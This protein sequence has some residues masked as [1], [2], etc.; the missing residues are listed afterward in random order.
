MERAR[1]DEHLQNSQP[2]GQGQR[3]CLSHHDFRA[4]T[5]FLPCRITTS[6]IMLKFNI[7]ISARGR[8]SHTYSQ[9]SLD[10][11]VFQTIP[12]L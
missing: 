4:A 10:S 11:Y 7:I 2:S 1:D 9:K 5:T 8:G 6:S 12:V 3:P